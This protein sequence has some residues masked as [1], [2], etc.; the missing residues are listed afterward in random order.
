M[1]YDLKRPCKECPFV[2]GTGTNVTLEPGRLEDIKNKLKSDSTFTCH[3]TLEMPKANQQHCAGALIYL[4]KIEQPNN[5][6]RIMERLGGYDHTKLD[7]T[8]DIDMTSDEEE[9]Y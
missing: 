9:G 4:E 8:A 2:C 6:M 5:M 7:M 3:K 1:N